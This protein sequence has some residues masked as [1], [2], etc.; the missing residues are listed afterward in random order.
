LLIGVMV[1][2]CSFTVE[3]IG[4]GND[5]S[6]GD[7]SPRDMSLDDLTVGP[8]M[9]EP[10]DLMPGPSCK[11]GIKNGTESDIDCG[12]GACP[13]C[14][15]TQ[16]CA[17]PSDCLSGICTASACAGGLVAYYN[18]DENAGTQAFDSSGNNNHGLLSGGATWVPGK[19]GSSVLFTGAPSKVQV[20]DSASLDLTSAM[21]ISAW[22][23]A[24]A[25]PAWGGIVMK[26][27]DG[28]FSDGYGLY[29]RDVTG[30]LCGYINLYF[31]GSS[32]GVFTTTATFRHIAIT[33]DQITLTIYIDGVVAGTLPATNAISTNAAPLLIGQAAGG[34]GWQGKIDEVRIFNR[35]LSPTEINGLFTS[36]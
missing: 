34:Y 28:N 8:D 10:P 36:P 35:L 23:T 7:L 4:F 29:Y 26:A 30:P 9:T 19:V 32:C 15:T 22:V 33:Y 11:D 18:F 2:G 27:S 14:G 25:L 31:T 13:R 6:V 16:S 12:G 1:S 24:S 5:S 3:P 21:T 20:S 17:A